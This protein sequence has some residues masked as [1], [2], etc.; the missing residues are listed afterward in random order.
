MAARSVGGLALRTAHDAEK[1]RVCG[2]CDPDAGTRHRR[3]HGDFQLY[4]R[5]APAGYSSQGRKTARFTAMEGANAAKRRLRPIWRLRIKFRKWRYLIPAKH[6]VRL[7]VFSGVFSR[8]P[9]EDGGLRWFCC[10]CGH[11]SARFERQW[12][13]KHRAE[14]EICN[15]RIF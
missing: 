7:V 4:Q 6:G 12:S 14:A 3:K 1:P 11:I 8:D 5:R 15:W 13:G 10:F 2:H 9:E